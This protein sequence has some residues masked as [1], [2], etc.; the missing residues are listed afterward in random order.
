MKKLHSELRV[1][2]KIH[3]GIELKMVKEERATLAKVVT[4]GISEETIFDLRLI[5]EQQSCEGLRKWYP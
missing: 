4:E 2:Q 5:V 1:T 3:C